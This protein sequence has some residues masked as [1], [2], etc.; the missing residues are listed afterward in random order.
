MQW[1]SLS[2]ER[3]QMVSNNSE[4]P[5]F[6]LNI[7]AMSCCCAAL[8]NCCFPDHLL[9]RQI[10]CRLLGMAILT[11]ALDYSDL[12]SMRKSLK[13]VCKITMISIGSVIIVLPSFLFYL[14]FITIGRATFLK[15]CVQKYMLNIISS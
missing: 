1:R 15:A 5:L 13:R 6:S 7:Q 9:E 12:F 4:L 10:R 14:Y 8:W 2:W 3:G 11:F